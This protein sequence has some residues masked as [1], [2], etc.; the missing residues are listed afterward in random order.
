MAGC[1]LLAHVL[2]SNADHTPLG[3]AVPIYAR[4]GVELNA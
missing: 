4:E 3:S 2:V 1:G